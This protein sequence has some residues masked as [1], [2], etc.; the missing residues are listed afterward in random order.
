MNRP[1]RTKSRSAGS[2]SSS[3]PGGT[4]CCASPLAFDLTDKNYGVILG[5]RSDKRG[6]S[7]YCHV[8]LHT[9]FRKDLFR[10]WVC[11]KWICF[12]R[13]SVRSTASIDV[14]CRRSVNQFRIN[15]LLLSIENLHNNLPS[16][17]SQFILKIKSAA[18]VKKRLQYTVLYICKNMPYT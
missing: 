9:F 3:L 12:F 8:E 17:L 6:C 16:N 10:K 7:D 13:N 14:S 11:R 1:S 4:P 5:G 2:L 18:N 15:L